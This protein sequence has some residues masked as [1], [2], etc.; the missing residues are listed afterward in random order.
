MTRIDYYILQA[1]NEA[2]R[3]FF[4]CRVIEK[5]YKRGHQIYIY[6]ESEHLADKIDDALWSFRK[7]S[8]IPHNK[9]DEKI[10]L[11]SPIE[12]GVKQ[13]P[14]QHNDMM[15]NL[16]NNI[17]D[18]FS[19]FNRVAE[20]VSQQPE[21]LTACRINYAFYRDRGYPMHYHDLRNKN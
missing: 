6:T 11:S 20:I 12:I 9:L 21:I 5:A 14:I 17:P 19:R 13:Q 8:F 15:I 7:E 18:F 4:A 2:E 1:Q 3:L 10:I 16:S